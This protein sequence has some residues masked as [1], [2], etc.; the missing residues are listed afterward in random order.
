M[1]RHLRT[2]AIV[3]ITCGLLAFFPSQRQ[4]RPSVARN[5]GRAQS[6]FWSS[7]RSRRS[8]CTCS[9]RFDGR[10]CCDRLESRGFVRH[11]GQ[12]FI[13]FA[14]SALLPA[15]PG[16]VLRP[17]LLARREGLSAT[18]RLRPSSSSGCSTSSRCSC[19]SASSCW[20]SSR[21]SGWPAAVCS[22]RSRS[23]G[24]SARSAPSRR[25]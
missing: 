22:V 11:C 12:R 7:R 2:V 6:G 21:V 14:A 24:L 17:Y 10:C 19:C 23:A 25:W 15:R 4:S 20:P 1:R 3:G 8:C 16:E 18:G 5:P 13:G 9:A